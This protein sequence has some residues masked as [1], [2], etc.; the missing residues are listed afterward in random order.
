MSGFFPVIH[1][2]A[3]TSVTQ[4]KIRGEGAFRVILIYLTK[5]S[6][7][8]RG[9]PPRSQRG[10]PIATEIF[11][12]CPKQNNS[13][14]SHTIVQLA[15]LARRL[16]G[17]E[18]ASVEPLPGHAD[19][20]YC[21]ATGGGEK[22]VLKLAHDGA[23]AAFW[24]FQRALLDHLSKAAPGACFPRLIATV[25]GAAHARAL[26]DGQTRRLLLLSW[27]PGRMLADTRPHTEGLLESMGKL[28]GRLSR[29][30][31]SFDHPAAHREMEWD[32][33]QAHWVGESLDLF[34]DPS[35]RE[36]AEH[37]WS[38]YQREAA[39]RIPHLRH[40]VN[41]NDANDYN[42]LVDD[43]LSDPRA[44]AL[45]D[46]GD[47]VYTPVVN[48]L[49]IGLAYALLDK[50]DP[51]AAAVPLARAYCQEFPLDDEELA[52][53][54]P[55]MCAR[56]LLSVV[57]ST[58]NRARA[59]DNPYLL[60]SE[61]P[62]WALLQRLR[63]IP[64]AL[65]HYTFRWAAG[66]TPCPQAERFRDWIGR[67]QL[68]FHA[69]VDVDLNG[70]EIQA[71]D[72]SVGST[73]L[74][75]NANFESIEAFDRAIQSMLW[76]R[77]AKGG[78][79][80]YSEARPFYAADAYR[81]LGNEG[82]IW[83]SVHLGL[84]VWLSAGTP[85]H[86]PLE[87]VVW[88]VR[89]N[90]GERD[91]GPT[92]ILA[93]R[94]VEGLCFF[95]LYGHLSRASVNHLRPGD[96][97]AAGQPIAAIG[98]WPENG[99]WPPH[100]HF[101]VI[102]DLLDAEGDFPGATYPHSREVWLSICPDPAPLA[103]YRDAPAPA[104]ASVKEMIDRRQRMLGPSLSLSYRAPLHI[105]RGYMQYLYD[106]SGRRYLDTVNNVAHV[107]HEHPEV[108]RAGQRQ[109]A[110]LNTNTRYLHEE[111]LVYAEELL[112]HFSP[113][114][115]VVYFVN[116]GSEANELAMR[117]AR[118]LTGRED[119]IA[120]EA[121]YHG[122]TGAC[123]AISPYKFDGPGGSGAPPGT[124]VAPMPDGY[125][126]AYRG[127]T[128]VASERYADALASAIQI[129]AERGR[130]PAAFIAESILSCGGQIV[131]PPGY[132]EAAYRHARAAGALCIADEVQTGFGR[133]GAH[134]WAYQLHGVNPDIVTLGKPIGNGHPLGAVV[135][136]RTIAETFANGMEYFNTY[137]GNPV[138]CAAGRAVLRII[139]EEGL[140]ERALNTG[141]YLRERLLA[142][143]ARFPL[144]GEV[145]GP[146]LFQGM[147][148]TRDPD[149]RAPATEACAY[150]VERMRAHGIL[151]SSDGPQ[152]N[153]LKI[154]PPLC[155]SPG[156]VDFIVET[157]EKILMEDY[158]KN[159][160]LT[161]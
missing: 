99:N 82:P 44:T 83:R 104:P 90:A 110:V 48:E 121:G 134:F 84:D 47:A 20:N 151:M 52:A 154:K 12:S 80:G 96:I 49:A 58:R 97:V 125:R 78:V 85:V 149:T 88:S 33:G 120:L 39:S 107:G 161:S 40:G 153:V 140:Q 21:L 91:Y 123:V 137:G 77:R 100:L 57:H 6:L 46:F 81:A 23:N 114:L 126:G 98:H 87:G 147:E 1:D 18:A 14:N 13:L 156:D 136:R 17:I 124:H 63:N 109:M 152:R 19:E 45:V 145:R 37:F 16:F 150:L 31:Q 28:L 32:P 11:L 112:S 22:Y 42:I 55:L 139:R 133:V 111:I 118:H 67:R 95:T 135:T 10:K 116:S 103:G 72:L 26:F 79:G 106:A 15:D 73:E 68:P 119:F 56:L 8:T 142:L 54:F 51:L 5:K 157:L 132:L 92:L 105:V 66:K 144:I 138:S 64:P 131:P 25:E 38:L 41:H 30:M 62:V 7:H 148:L 27:L 122:N 69:L 50:P 158:L 86:A 75:N 60:V 70:P 129:M 128:R 74:G 155:F 115:S 59:E 76:K 127:H 143:Q 113:E 101:Q 29:A 93:H 71:L 24:D 141:S 159:L 108:V 36:L 4:A 130:A 117:M 61:R 34:D 146:G 9:A 102:L 160:V 2:P 94:P 89:D 53:L 43:N 3:Q 65:A 35:Q